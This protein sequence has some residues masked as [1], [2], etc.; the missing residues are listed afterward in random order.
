MSSVVKLNVVKHEQLPVLHGLYLKAWEASAASAD[1]DA[2]DAEEAY[3][4]AIEEYGREVSFE[5]SGYV[6]LYLRTYLERRG[7]ELGKLIFC[8]PPWERGEAAEPYETAISITPDSKALLPQ[9]DPAAHAA[10]AIAQHFEEMGYGYETSGADA[11]QALSLLRDV[12]G[13]LAHDE[14]LLVRDY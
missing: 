12:I 8:P 1:D 10:A 13:G 6:F 2:F 4:D 11:L 7:V 3:R 5:W 9:L 14:V